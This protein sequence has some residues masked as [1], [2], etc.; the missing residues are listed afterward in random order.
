MWSISTIHL[1]VAGDMGI[2]KFS[3][4]DNSL[5]LKLLPIGHKNQAIGW[6]GKTLAMD[7]AKHFYN[8]KTF[9]SKIKICL[10]TPCY[11]LD[12][13]TGGLPI[14]YK[15]LATKLVERDH[16]VTVLYA[17]RF[18]S[19]AK[20][21]VKEGFEFIPVRF[22]LPKI[23][24]FFVL[25]KLIRNLGFSEKSGFHKIAGLLPEA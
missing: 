8:R 17:D 9:G 24:H 14:H 15:R 10:V 7:R 16:Q 20:H 5:A 1:L 22:T 23:L 4:R 21:E 12:D 2:R 3:V 13:A 6:C 25:S 19:P 18:G 11:E